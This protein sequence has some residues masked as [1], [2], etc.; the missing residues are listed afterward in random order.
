MAIW[1]RVA[2][3]VSKATRSQ[4]HSSAR[5]PTLN[6]SHTHELTHTHTHTHTHKQICNTCCFFH[7]NNGFVNARHCYVTRTLRVLLCLVSSGI[8]TASGF[9]LPALAHRWTCNWQDRRGSRPP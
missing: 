3:W 8:P 5:A 6:P 2:C 4:A 7:G 1:R 9:V